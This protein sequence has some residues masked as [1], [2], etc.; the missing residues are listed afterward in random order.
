MNNENLILVF[1]FIKKPSL[2][3]D[4]QLIL[5]LIPFYTSPGR[6][7]IEKIP[8]Y[9]IERIWRALPKEGLQTKRQ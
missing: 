5:F 4:F 8:Y 1:S 6:G 3:P 9:R 2:D 7:F